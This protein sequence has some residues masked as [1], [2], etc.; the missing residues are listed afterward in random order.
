MNTSKTVESVVAA[1][2]IE[3]TEDELMVELVDGK[4]VIVP[5][6]W[7]PRLLH[8]TQ[9]ERERFELIARGTGIHWPLLDEDLSVTSILNG[10]PSME[11][12][13][14]LKQWLESRKQGP[15]ESG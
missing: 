13:S 2:R 4:K 7:Y 9:V 10:F 1:S 5:L 12:Q 3:T 6:V 8:G 11:T 14:S 15:Q